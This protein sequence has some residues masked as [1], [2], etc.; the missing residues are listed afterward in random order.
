MSP[1]AASQ[2]HAQSPIHSSFD[3]IQLHGLLFQTL[4]GIN[5][6]EQDTLQPVTIDL[7]LY[8]MPLLA[9]RTDDLTQSI[10]YATVYDQVAHLVHTHHVGLVERLAGLIAETLLK[11][12]PALMALDVAVYK[13]E[14]PLPGPFAQAGISIRRTR[15]DFG[16]LTTATLSLGANQGD[17]LET[18]KQAVAL[19]GGHPQNHLI[20]TSSVYQTTPVGLVDQPDFFNLV[21]R[22]ETSLD[23][24]ALLD[25]CQQIEQRFARERVLRWGPRTLD[26]DLLTYGQLNSESACLSLPHPRMAER[27][28]VQ[29]PLVELETGDVRATPD[30]RFACKLT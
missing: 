5:P 7:N 20:G 26:I 18:L 19:L 28:F 30:V 11:K 29:I 12:H 13:P 8:L 15:A 3:R 21:V 6:E 27:D 9:C 4:I 17:C 14:A 10:S 25:F 22:L 16:L 2:G 1:H 23:P 24:F